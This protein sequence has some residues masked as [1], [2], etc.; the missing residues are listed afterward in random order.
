[1]EAA[2]F[3]GWLA[4]CCSGGEALCY[5]DSSVHT[6]RTTH[7]ATRQL[8]GEQREVTLQKGVGQRGRGT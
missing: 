8:Q 7:G 1:M 2:T 6:L 3:R 4:K 5:T